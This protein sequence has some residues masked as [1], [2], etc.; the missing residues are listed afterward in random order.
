MDAFSCSEL[1][2]GYGGRAVATGISFSLPVGSSLAIIG[3][4]G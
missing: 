4:N 1:S 2:V 3:S